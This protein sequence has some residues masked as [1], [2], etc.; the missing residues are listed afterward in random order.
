M[1]TY[2]GLDQMHIHL[3]FTRLAS[4]F[5]MKFKLFNLHTLDIVVQSP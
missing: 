4:V 1:F 5:R 3:V 2:V